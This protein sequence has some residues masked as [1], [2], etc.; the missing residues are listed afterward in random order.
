MLVMA[1]TGTISIF[2]GVV[3]K[4]GIIAVMFMLSVGCIIRIYR[5]SV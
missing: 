3:V 1:V 2:A 5:I 4:L